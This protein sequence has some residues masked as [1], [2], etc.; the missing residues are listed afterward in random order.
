MNGDVLLEYHYRRSFI[1]QD[2]N[3][4][5]KIDEKLRSL[6]DSFLKAPESNS[7]KNQGGTCQ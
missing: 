4:G 3:N 6:L 5:I 7:Q 2:I 1:N